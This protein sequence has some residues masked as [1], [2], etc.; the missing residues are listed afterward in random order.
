MEFSFHLQSQHHGIFILFSLASASIVTY[1][2]VVTFLPPSYKD[3]YDYIK[4]SWI[5]QHILCMLRSLTYSL[6][7]LSLSCKVTYSQDIKE[8]KTLPSW[9]RGIILLPRS[10]IH[11]TAEFQAGPLTPLFSLFLIPKVRLIPLKPVKT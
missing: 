7:I 6:C 11:N 8:I 10:L 3:I 1:F 4:P 9:G 2:L 5:I